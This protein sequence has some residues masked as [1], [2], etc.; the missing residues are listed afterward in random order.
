MAFDRFA[1]YK[2]LYDKELA[3]QENINT[4]L[5]LHLSVSVL[6]VGLTA[7]IMSRLNIPFVEAECLSDSLAFLTVSALILG[8]LGFLTMIV[9]LL[10]VYWPTRWWSER[11]D[12]ARSAGEIEQVYRDLLEYYDALYI[13][14]DKSSRF[15]EQASLLTRWNT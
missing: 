15:E 9:L 5:N 2:E 4:A 8:A 13:E 7:Y 10:S 11:Y 1:Y 3:L 12:D 6:L 14:E